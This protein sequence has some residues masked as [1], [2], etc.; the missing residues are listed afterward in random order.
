MPQARRVPCSAH[1]W[2]SWPKPFWRAYWQ[3]RWRLPWGCRASNLVSHGRCRVLDLG[4]TNHRGS[5]RCEQAAQI[6]FADTAE[7]VL[8]PTRVLL[9]HQADPG[10]EV[11][12]R[13]ESLWIDDAGQAVANAG[14]TPG[15]PLAHLVGS[16]PSHDPAVE[17]RNPRL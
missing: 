6:L 2:P 15:S 13:L 9:W 14:P 16:M 3:A 8:V 1:P 11:P 10:R 7:F 5:A 4:V 17:P 12:P